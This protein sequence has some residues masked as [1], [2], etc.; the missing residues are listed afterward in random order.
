MLNILYSDVILHIVTKPIEE[1]FYR[2][3]GSR[4]IKKPKL[5]AQLI[6]R[7]IYLDDDERQKI[8]K[9]K[10]EFLIER[11]RYGGKHTYEYKDFSGNVLTSKL[12]FHDPCKYLLWTS[13]IKSK[14]PSAKDKLDWTY[15]GYRTRDGDGRLTVKK[16]SINKT[17]IQFNGRDRETYKTTEYYNAVQPYSKY[18]SSLDFGENLYSYAMLPLLLQP[19]GAV[20][21]TQIAIGRVQ[22]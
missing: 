10:M 14:T 4:F 8:A 3:E 12:F 19:S 7:Y 21:L 22:R 1:I 17:K 9:S 5:G 13:K 20:N 18:T 11:Y 6:T 15:Y 16:P 2:D